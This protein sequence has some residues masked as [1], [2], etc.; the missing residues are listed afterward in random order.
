[1]FDEFYQVHNNERDRKKG[2]GLGLAIARRLAGQLGGD[3]AVESAVGAGSRFTV[4]LQ[5][6]I[7]DVETQPRLD[8]PRPVLAS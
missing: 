3:V 4:A 7:A 1:L 5:G 2:F 8:Q 6:V